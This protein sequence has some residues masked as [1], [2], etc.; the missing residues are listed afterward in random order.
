MNI[1]DLLVYSKHLDCNEPKQHT[2][3]SIEYAVEVLE[4][5]RR[6]YTVAFESGDVDEL[7]R[8]VPIAEILNKIKTLKAQLI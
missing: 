7:E 6:G 1:R 4:E 8:A 5:L 2:K 3:V